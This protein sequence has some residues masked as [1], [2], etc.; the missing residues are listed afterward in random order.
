MG[1]DLGRGRAPI[2][3]EEARSKEAEVFQRQAQQSG[4]LEVALQVKALL[5][6]R[7]FTQ[8]MPGAQPLTSEE[9]AVWDLVEGFA[10]RMGATIQEV[11]AGHK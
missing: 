8:E 10:Q 11:E 9:K 1:I 7:V 4:K 2:S 5:R 6:G 3:L